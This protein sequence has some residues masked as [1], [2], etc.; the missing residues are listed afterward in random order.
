MWKVQTIGWKIRRGHGRC[1]QERE[2]G[3]RSSEMLPNMHTHRK[4]ASGTR[5]LRPFVGNATEHVN[6]S[7]EMHHRNTKM[8][9]ARQ[10]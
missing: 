6:R 8:A 1:H 10:K 7:T 2:N 5:M 9:T 4:S 3:D